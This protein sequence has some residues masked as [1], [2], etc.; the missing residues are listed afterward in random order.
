M[1]IVFLL[2]IVRYSFRD[3]IC[4]IVSMCL[5]S[6]GAL[7]QSTDDMMRRV[8]ID[9]VEVISSRKLSEIGG[10]K[11]NLDTLLFKSNI[12]SSM[13]EVL[14]MTTGVYVKHSGRAS[15]STVA[16]RGAGASHTQVAWNGLKINSPMMGQV[17]FSTMPAY[18]MREGRVLYAATSLAETSGGLGGS[19]G[20][21]A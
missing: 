6:A 8:E 1:A 16:I 19:Y 10:G 7:A 13:A 20:E 12:S 4:I 21:R 9:E 15:L 5:S 3:I 11:S 14:L 17:D 18:F 2:R